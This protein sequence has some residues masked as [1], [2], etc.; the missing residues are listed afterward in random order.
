MEEGQGQEE[1]N[2]D[3]GVQYNLGGEQLRIIGGLLQ[4]AAT[5]Y[6][7][8]QLMSWFFALKGVKLNIINRLNQAE[9]KELQEME[10]EITEEASKAKAMDFEWQQKEKLRSAVGRLIEAYSIRISDL[11][12]TK[13]FLIPLKDDRADL[14]FKGEG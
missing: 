4:K 9:R 10:V 5:Y 7:G 2:K 8:G 6:L 3:S 11:L 12:E 1:G 13:G 14:F